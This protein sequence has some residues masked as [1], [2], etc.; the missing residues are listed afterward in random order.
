MSVCATAL[1]MMKLLVYWFFA[2]RGRMQLT[3]FVGLFDNI[4]HS[5][6]I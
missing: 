1:L 3:H 4:F 6:L 5:L 2:E